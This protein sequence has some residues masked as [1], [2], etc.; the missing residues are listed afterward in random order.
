MRVL[1][2]LSEVRDGISDLAGTRESTAVREVIDVDFIKDQVELGAYDWG[3]C[4]RLVGGVVTI[5]RR[6]QSPMRDG[7]T[8][9]KWLQVGASML[10][11]E[12]ID[13]PRVM[14]KAL[15]FLLDRVN[16]MRVDAANAR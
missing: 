14:C 5:I 10:A 2:V 3:A 7:E 11:A 8:Q 12:S 16:A 15:E 9:Q 13:R 1:R 6:V 4:K